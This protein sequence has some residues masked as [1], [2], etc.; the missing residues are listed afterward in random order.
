MDKGGKGTSRQSGREAKAKAKAISTAEPAR[1]ARKGAEQLFTELEAR[2]LDTGRGE[3]QSAEGAC[4]QDGC[5]RGWSGLLH[6]GAVMPM[7]VGGKQVEEKAEVDGNGNGNG[8]GG[9]EEEWRGRMIDQACKLKRIIHTVDE[10]R[11]AR[12]WKTASAS[13]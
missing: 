9:D 8:N 10:K 13:R 2:L 11:E 1:R 4:P 12:A 7:S 6:E 5:G 3:D